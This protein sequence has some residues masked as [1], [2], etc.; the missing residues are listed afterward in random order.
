[1]PG[2]AGLRRPTAVQTVPTQHPAQQAD[3]RHTEIVHHAQQQVRHE[4]A[5]RKHQGHPAHVAQA[6]FLLEPTAGF[7]HRA[8]MREEAVFEPGHEYQ[9]ELQALG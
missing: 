7:L 2:G 8:L 1:M 5:Q 3:G 9:R 4:P 6:T